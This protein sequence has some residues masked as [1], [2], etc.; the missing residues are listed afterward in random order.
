MDKKYSSDLNEIIA[1]NLQEQLSARNL[2]MAMI[3]RNNIIYIKKFNLIKNFF[4]FGVFYCCMNFIM[5]KLFCSNVTF[6]MQKNVYC[7]LK[8][9]N[10]TYYCKLGYYWSISCDF[11]KLTLTRISEAAYLANSRSNIPI[12]NIR[13]NQARLQDTE[14]NQIRN[15]EIN[16]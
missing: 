12:Q 15:E 6:H 7:L 1:N 9:E 5:T 2:V 3:I 10:E 11:S 16:I 13:S 14:A 4:C 8:I